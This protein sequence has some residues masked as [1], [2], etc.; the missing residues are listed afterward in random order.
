MLYDMCVRRQGAPLTL[1]AGTLFNG[2]G[3]LSWSN[4]KGSIQPYQM[5]GTR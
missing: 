2:T 4:W 1:M 3:L 5:K